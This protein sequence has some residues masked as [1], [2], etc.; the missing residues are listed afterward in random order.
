MEPKKLASSCTS[1]RRRLASFSS[2]SLAMLVCGLALLP[3]LLSLSR[4]KDEALLLPVGF[5]LPKMIGIFSS[6]ALV[7]FLAAFQARDFL[8]SREIAS[9]FVVLATAAVLAVS[10]ALELPPPNEYDKLPFLLFFP[11]AVVGGWTLSDYANRGRTA[12]RRHLR[13]IA[14]CLLAFAPLNLFM[15]AAYYNTEPIHRVQGDER[16]VVSWVRD[17]TP[18]DAVFMDTGER[19]FLIAAGPRR[20]F[21]GSKAYAA[22]WGY[23]RR[24]IA[25]RERVIDEVY[26]GGPL[27]ET[28]LGALRELPYPV[29]VIVRDGDPHAN[30]AAFEERASFDRVFSSGSVSVYEFDKSAVESAGSAPSAAPSEE[31]TP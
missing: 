7:I 10:A 15:F 30:A 12:A 17:N 20:Y 8:R 27:G 28:T 2:I 22:T 9:R 5:S 31:E 24:E 21:L 26:S 11:L 3:Y 16:D 29:Y 14:L 6:C 18:R 4:A 13:M 23:D 1:A 19:V 25:R